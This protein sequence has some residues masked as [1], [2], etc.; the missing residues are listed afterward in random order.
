MIRRATLSDRDQIIPLIMVILKDMELPFLDKY[1]EQTTIELLKKGFETQDYRYSYHRAIV[2]EEDK[3]VVGVAFGYRDIEENCIDRPLE[4][5]FEAFGIESEDKL[6]VDS[7]VGKNEWYL[8]TISVRDDQR[9]KGIGSQLLA[10]L[11]D[12]CDY[13]VIGLNV[14]LQNPK[15]EK[16]YEKMGFKTV[17]EMTLS[18]HLYHHMQKKIG[19]KTN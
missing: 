16:L 11:P 2:A 7:E 15:A 3:E 5:F 9:G 4:A 14:D 19:T 13:P 6:F 8:D 10:A 17:G 12:F 18:G 1:G